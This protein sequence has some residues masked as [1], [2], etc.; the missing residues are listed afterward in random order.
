VY[1]SAD[2][3]DY[4]ALTAMLVLIQSL[5]G[6]LGITILIAITETRAAADTAQAFTNGQQL[7]FTL[8]IPLLVASVIVSFL[9]RTRR[10]QPEP[11]VSA[12]G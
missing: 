7:A 10:R 3:A 4:G 5:A 8:L 12:R 6:T 2:R 11:V 9:G 1:A